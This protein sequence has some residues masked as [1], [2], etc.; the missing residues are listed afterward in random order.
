MA[1]RSNRTPRILNYYRVYLN[2]GDSAR[3]VRDV[4]LQYGVST[5][6]RLA[7]SHNAEVRRAAVLA[8]GILGDRKCIA[9]LGQMLSDS[10]RT[11]RIVADDSMKSI[12]ERTTSPAGRNLLDQIIVKLSDEDYPAAIDLAGKLVTLQ[13][14]LPEAY[15][16]RALAY[17]ANGD[18][19]AAIED[20]QRAIALNEYE[21]MAIVGLGQCY[22]EL[23]QPRIALDYFRQ[24]ITIYPD[25][26]PVS[27]QIRK[28]EDSLRETI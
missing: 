22:L 2:D 13:P 1:Q 21:Y 5:L 15:C 23:E 19:E 4:A 9:L 17:Y 27:A 16:Q 26:E 25:L 28:L 10:D 7:G 14:K 6:Q 3:F 24:A 11:V 12:W 8:L 20:C 18:T